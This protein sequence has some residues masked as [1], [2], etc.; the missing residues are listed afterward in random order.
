MTTVD[1]TTRRPDPVRP[2]APAAGGRDVLTLF[3]GVRA[4]IVAALWVIGG[5]PHALTASAADALDSLGRLSGLIAAD[6]LLV[7]VLLM[8]RVPVIERAYG[9]DELARRHRLV[10]F[11]SVNLLVVHIVLITLG[12]ALGDGSNVVAEAWTLVTTYDGMLLAAAGTAALLVVAVT[13]VRAARRRLRYESWHLLHL[14]A[15]L[16][17]GCRSRTRSGRA[18]TSPARPSPACTGGARTPSRPGRS[19]P[20]A[21]A[22]RCGG[23]GGTGS[24]SPRSCPRDRASSPST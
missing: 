24:P 13:S 12:Y 8:A 15:Y 21:S 16:G 9:Q 11:W 18:R 14:Y 19:S 2:A 3:C 4:A 6:L 23:P 1:V 10:G 5:Q 17:V 7:Q 22:C 20:T